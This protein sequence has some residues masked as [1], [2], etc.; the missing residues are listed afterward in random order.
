MVEQTALCADTDATQIQSVSTSPGQRRRLT[1]LAEVLSSIYH[2][3]TA[4]PNLHG[5]L[6]ISVLI[7]W[8]Q[9]YDSILVEEEKMR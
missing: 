8:C 2:Y 1:S 6:L 9:V 4:K 7:L 5:T 3:S